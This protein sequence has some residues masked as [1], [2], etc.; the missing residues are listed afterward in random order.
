MRTSTQSA[1]L[2]LVFILS[3]LVLSACSGA[4]ASPVAGYASRGDLTTT[5][6]AILQVVVALIMLV[7]LFTLIIPGVPGITFI[8]IAAL[9]YALVTGFEKPTWLYFGIISGLMLL[10]N[11]V[12]NLM[13]GAGARKGGAPWLTTL[14]SVLAAII[15]SLVFP[16]FGGIIAAAIVLFTLE[17]IRLKDSRTALRSTGELLKGFGCSFVVRFFIGMIMIALWVV[18]IVQAGQW[19]L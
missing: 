6:L 3:M 13:M 18:W 1:L 2:S 4:T 10:G 17:V 7:S 15:G 14:A 5:T 9:I 8:W 12:D 19:L 16:P 11:V